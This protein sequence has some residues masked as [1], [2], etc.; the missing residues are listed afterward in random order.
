MH[1]TTGIET[2][3]VVVEATVISHITVGHT[4]WVPIRAKTE[5]PRKTDTRRTWCG[6]TRYREVRETVPDRAVQYFIVKLM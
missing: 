5:V 1:N 2:E 3:D 4:E 6:A